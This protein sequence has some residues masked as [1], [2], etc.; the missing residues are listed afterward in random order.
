MGAE[1]AYR[2]QRRIGSGLEPPEPGRAVVPGDRN[3]IRVRGADRELAD[4]RH[5]DRGAD[6]LERVLVEQDDTIPGGT[7][8]QDAAAGEPGEGSGGLILG[9]R[10]ELGL[11]EQLARLGARQ[12]E[13]P[14]ASEGPE[15]AGRVGLHRNDPSLPGDERHSTL[16][17][18][19]TGYRRGA[20]PE[21]VRPGISG[22]ANHAQRR[23]APVHPH[24][25]AERHRVFAHRESADGAVHRAD[26]QLAAAF[27]ER[28]AEDCR[29]PGLGHRRC[30]G[31]ACDAVEVEV[32]HKWP[33]RRA[34][35]TAREAAVVGQPQPSR[36]DSR[37][38]DAHGGWIRASADPE[39]PAITHSDVP[40]RVR[41]AGLLAEPF[42][43]CGA[44]FVDLQIRPG[45]PRVENRQ[46]ARPDENELPGVAARQDLQESR[47]DLTDL[48][49]ERLA[50]RGIHHEHLTPP[51]DYRREPARGVEE[52]VL[53]PRRNRV[54]D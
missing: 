10:R 45:I 28:H 38:R 8:E 43:E 3:E 12:Q 7:G 47:L 29:K 51:G 41:R 44:G 33:A 6:G 18:T 48:A 24:D 53:H 31:E 23:D 4:R 9:M 20:L 35:R 54:A 39:T 52:R 34:N 26:P 32:E 14:P 49:V 16:P 27:R 37:Q 19:H 30:G 11:A 15:P 22:V 5:G 13:M 42:E 25:L 50:G 40:I 2:A 17:R 21:V 1:L 36:T 46:P